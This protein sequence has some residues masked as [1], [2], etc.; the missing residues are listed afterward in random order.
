MTYSHSD[1]FL[2][3]LVT[4]LK[5]KYSTYFQ[6]LIVQR[7]LGVTWCSYL[8]RHSTS[9]RKQQLSMFSS[10]CQHW[11]TFLVFFLC[12]HWFLQLRWHF[13]KR[14]SPQNRNKS[15]NFIFS[16]RREL[17]FP[18]RWLVWIS[19]NGPK[20][21]REVQLPLKC[22]ICTFECTLFGLSMQ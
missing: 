22:Y 3:G 9:S 6:I 16:L 14:W 12:H 5:G 8:T 17:K 19:G 11:W 2:S 13:L 4:Y 21:A 18:S 1:G 15:W 20:G 7:K 10:S